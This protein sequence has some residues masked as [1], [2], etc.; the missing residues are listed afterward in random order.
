[1]LLEDFINDAV[2]PEITLPQN[3]QT[4]SVTYA[5]S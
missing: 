5:D 3:A 4:S 2:S 1:M